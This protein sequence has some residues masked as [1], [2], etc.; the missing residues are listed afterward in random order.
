ML[1]VLA[2]NFL[3]FS[4]RKYMNNKIKRWYN[5]YSFSR[6]PDEDGIYEMD[7]LLEDNTIKKG[8]T[9]KAPPENA[10]PEHLKCR[11]RKHHQ[12]RNRFRVF[13]ELKN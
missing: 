11:I 1:I 2:F 3:E 4:L 6:I 9:K 8:Y 13:W 10:L 12:K 5:V 7:F